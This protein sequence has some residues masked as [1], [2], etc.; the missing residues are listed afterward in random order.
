MPSTIRHRTE[1]DDTIQSAKRP[2]RGHAIQK[3]F[4][5]GLLDEETT[6][7]LNREYRRS[8][9]FL[10]A[11]VDQLFQDD[12]LTSVKDECLREL[13]FTEKQTDIYRVRQVTAH[14]CIHLNGHG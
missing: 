7:R 6:D 14:S 2:K 10:H 13:S 9:P 11:V 4:A 1:P 5:D 12:L 3:I 8:K